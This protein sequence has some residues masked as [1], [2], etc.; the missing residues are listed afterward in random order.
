[1]AG[2]RD[3]VISLNA[4]TTALESSIA[5]S[6]VFI[7]KEMQKVS[8][9]VSAMN[10]TFQSSSRDISAAL[11]TL[12]T[13][14]SGL[15][16]ALTRATSGF[17]LLGVGAAIAIYGVS[18]ALEAG[19]KTVDDYQIG[20]ISIAA[21]LTNMT[22]PGQGSM[23]QIFARNKA[24]A[25]Q[26][27]RAITL[28]AAK[29]F[30]TANEMM[31][32][33]NKLVQGGYATRVKEVEALG[34]LTDIIKVKTK[35]QDVERQLNTE[36]MAMMQGQAR[37]G[38]LLAQE[39]QQRLGPGWAELVQQHLRAGDLLTWIISLYPGF[40][41]ANREITDTLNSQWAT[42]ESI[43][44]LIGIGGLG[45][46][47]KDITNSVRT[48][49]DYLRE[50]EQDI[51]VGI[52][53]SWATVKYTIDSIGG[54]IKTIQTMNSKI[55]I[56]D[57]FLSLSSKGADV[58]EGLWSGFAGGLRN[59]VKAGEASIEI[60]AKK[61]EDLVKS[62][63]VKTGLNIDTDA[64]Y[65]G[66][67]KLNYII[68]TLISKLSKAYTFVINTVQSVLPSWTDKSQSGI[69]PIDTSLEGYKKDYEMMA[70]GQQK[71][72]L[73]TQGSVVLS[74][75]IA[76]S[77]K[78]NKEGKMYFDNKPLQMQQGTGDQGKGG[79]GAESAANRLENFVKTMEEQMAKAS[80][81]S[82]AALEGWYSKQKETLDQISEKYKQFYDD[83][84]EL[85][86]A[87]DALDSTMYGKAGKIAE[88]FYKLSA[89]ESG[90][91]Y[92]EI[93]M[94][95]REWLLKYKGIQ[96]MAR[97]ILEKDAA[98][99]KSLLDETAKARLKWAAAI[100]PA[101]MTGDIT[102]RK[103][104]EENQKQVAKLEDL[105]K[106]NLSVLMQASPFLLEQFEL[107][108][109]IL[110]ITIKKN[111]AE[112][113]L[114]I[115]KIQIKDIE[116]GKY[117]FLL[118]SEKQLLVAERLRSDQA[119]RAAQERKGWEFQGPIGGVAIFALELQND[120]KTA[121]AR[122][123]LDGL[124]SLKSSADSAITDLI[125]SPFTKKKADFK[126]IGLDIATSIAGGL[127][128]LGTTRLFSAF[129]EG[130]MSMVSTWQTAQEAMTA[131]SL[132]GDA[133]RVTSTASG[134]TQGLSIMGALAKG[135]ILMEA[136][137]SG[138]A[139]FT[140]VM[141]ALPFPINM[142]LAPLAAAAAFAAT[143]AFGSGIMGGGGKESVSESLR[144][145]SFQS[146]AGGDFRVAE[147]GLRM[148]H[149]EETILP[150]WA[151]DSWREI[152]S[153]GGKGP[154]ENGQPEKA[155]PAISSGGGG[156]T[157]VHAPITFAPVY[158]YRPTQA[159]MDRD[160]RMMLRSLNKH[161]SPYNQTLGDGKY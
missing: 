148:I 78:I 151:A 137:R 101:K 29:H 161:L 89:K 145:G 103:N 64:A 47:Y 59:W 56:I 21:A 81:D 119:R 135:N 67:N 108:K 70:R 20:I 26:M 10:S 107:E 112:Q 86:R 129:T 160:A 15:P 91:H 9:S 131:A 139:A 66:L 116:T 120:S 17:A 11:M 133:A 18:K 104:W 136:G 24:E 92:A 100:D 52:A 38:S 48:I 2:L 141:E 124:K 93:E 13:G 88:D 55:P 125:M 114:A 69:T 51:A 35:G 6:T 98:R 42:T 65:Q 33:Y 157:V 5:K 40:V 23:D 147:T 49:N 58:T 25:E 130:A 12:N 44:A 102:G 158:N 83:T 155:A 75:E 97:D 149:K 94:Q 68:D 14:I 117:R 62:L 90:D 76:S 46:A 80:G 146:S 37:A 53:R 1:M 36:I 63:Q 152:V 159:D 79:A 32:V 156:Q 3:L 34:T 115:S 109:Q 126:K 82:A 128:K 41:A 110:E 60:L 50:H 153:Q 27:Y 19:I 4:N 43:V 73:P 85:A 87:K 105:H 138:A 95:G 57:N 121:T 77:L 123:V 45:G 22:K 140:S 16:Y 28:E 142:V 71:V 39:L 143:M 84:G 122:G 74:K 134:A 127:V 72:M 99:E 61:V 113:D 154:G 30:A 31:T 106:D 8:S 7:E 118:D 111:A 132:A 144:S 54:A 150:P 96:D